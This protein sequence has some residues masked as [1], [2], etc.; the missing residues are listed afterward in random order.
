MH[1][2]KDNGASITYQTTIEWHKN[3]LSD[4]QRQTHLENNG[5]SKTNENTNT[6]KMHRIHRKKNIYKQFPKTAELAKQMKHT[7]AYRKSFHRK[8][9]QT[10]PDNSETSKH[11]KTQTHQ[12]NTE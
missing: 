12:E 9:T 4:K 5:A 10:Q 1:I 2:Q 11:M 8:N 3:I 7:S 6:S